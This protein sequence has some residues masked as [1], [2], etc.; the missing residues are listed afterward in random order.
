MTDESGTKLSVCPECKDDEWLDIDSC[1]SMQITTVS[2]DC[3]HTFQS[4]CFEENVGR[5][6]NKHCKEQSNAIRKLDKN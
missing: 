3:G 4:K 1:G 6:W 2:C 5:H